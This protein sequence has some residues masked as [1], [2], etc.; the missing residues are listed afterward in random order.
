[1]ALKTLPPQERR[2]EWSD[3][4]ATDLA[5]STGIKQRTRE[6]LSPGR[7]SWAE[8]CD[9]LGLPA[10]DDPCIS[11]LWNPQRAVGRPSKK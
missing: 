9:M 3:F 7:G 1:M 2:A 11:V 6:P 5:A 10:M 8:P 4:S